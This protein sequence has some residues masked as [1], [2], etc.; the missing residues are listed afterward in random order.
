MPGDGA[1]RRRFVN[2]HLIQRQWERTHERSKLPGNLGEHMGIYGNL[3]HFNRFHLKA[4][5]S[6]NDS[7]WIQ[8]KMS[9]RLKTMLI[10][11]DWWFFPKPSKKMCK[12]NLDHV[13]LQ[14]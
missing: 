11:L 8:Q 9:R 3:L 6:R 13:Q 5:R 10:S 12:A 14:K 7:F 4:F 1:G 2:C